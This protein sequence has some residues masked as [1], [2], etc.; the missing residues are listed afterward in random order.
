MAGYGIL[1]LGLRHAPASGE[2]R[3]RHASQLRREPIVTETILA[4]LA[5]VAVVAYVTAILAVAAIGVIER[6]AALERMVSSVAPV[7]QLTNQEVIA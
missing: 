6:F 4:V 7:N 5:V 3:V 2:R 1:V